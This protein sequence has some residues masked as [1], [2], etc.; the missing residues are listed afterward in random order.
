[1]EIKES[2]TILNKVIRLKLGRYFS[3]KVEK[4]KIR[5]CKFNNLA[6]HWQ[7]FRLTP[8][9]KGGMKEAWIPRAGDEPMHKNVIEAPYGGAAGELA[10]DSETR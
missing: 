7:F 10:P 1:M 9:R 6:W 2:V 3:T 4:K 8:M 5:F